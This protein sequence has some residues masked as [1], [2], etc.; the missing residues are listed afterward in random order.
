M[1]NNGWLLLKT[2]LLSTSQRNIY[3]YSKD[4]K[5]RG[6]VIAGWIG[7]GILYLLLIA[8]CV[9]T[10]IGYGQMGIA[11]SIPVLCSLT[12][13]A[14]AFLLTLFKTN[15]YLFGFKEYDMLMSLPFEARTVAGCKFLYMY[16]QSLPWYLGI[17]LSM[18]AGYGIYERPGLSVYLIWICLSLVLPLIP[19]LIAAFL[20]F[21]IARVSSGFRNKTV[22]QTVLVTGVTL[23]LFA[24]R[25]LIEDMIRDDRV[26]ETLE[27]LA[28]LTENIAGVYPPAL[29]F[30]ESVTGLRI[31]R[32]LLLAG[33]SLLLFEAVFLTVGRSYRKINS[34]LHAHGAAG[35][36]R[37][38]AQKKHSVLLAIAF[39]ELRR[40][41]GSTVY[42]V[43]MGLGELFCLVLGLAV[44][45]LGFDRFI[46]LFTRNAPIETQMLFPSIPLIV[47]FLLGMVATTTASPSLEGKNYWIVKSL[48]IDSRDLYRGKMLFNL[49]LTLPFM[50]FATLCMCAS[51]RVPLGTT[52][53]YLVQGCA[54]LGFSS[55]WGCVCGIRF[56]RL[57]WENEVEVVKQGAA[58]ALYM[59]PNTFVT[60]GLV[61][62]SVFLGTRMDR[63]VLSLLF[64]A[65]TALLAF[66]CYRR[67]MTLAAKA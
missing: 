20:G 28:N 11:G 64:T 62:L 23:L 40:M 55:A 18:M 13:S 6:K 67:V 46:A 42:L 22:I 17:A 31:S 38:S 50:V 21:L 59:F 63:N 14:M 2:L 58:V 48:P 54:A 60:I 19:M 25:F 57:D 29:W 37:L 52:L 49:G 53:L 39:K 8:Y 1:K 10:S 15:G 5:K 30:A 36:Y 66:L 33:C 47:Y 51:A 61:V 3:K 45:I 34:S 12:I 4:K 16:C 7:F 9:A 65:V 41:L 44:L 27:S 35:Q 43:N 24:S 26:E 32:I 56:L